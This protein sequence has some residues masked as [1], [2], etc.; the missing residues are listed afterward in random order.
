MI[1]SIDILCGSR[2]DAIAFALLAS[3]DKLR[4][5]TIRLPRPVI[6]FPGAP[7]WIS[8]GTSCMLALSGLQEVAF[9]S[10]ESSTN[11][12]NDDKPDAAILRR[13]LTRP[14]GGLGNIRS[15]NGYL[16]V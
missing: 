7:I 4:K 10:C 12:M 9:G 15:I 8:D 2:E 5:I 13:E 14:R 11:Y 3:C 16:D 1:T 6:S